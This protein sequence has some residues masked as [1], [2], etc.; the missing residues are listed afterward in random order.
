M[1]ASRA[2]TPAQAIARAVWYFRASQRRHGRPMDPVDVTA[3]CD[4]LYP[5]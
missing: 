3:A 5:G 1:L 4:L 2:M